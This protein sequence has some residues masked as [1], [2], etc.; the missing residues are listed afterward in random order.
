MPGFTVYP[1]TKEVRTQLGLR[2]WTNGVVVDS[3]DP[4]LGTNP[5]ISTGD[6]IMV[7][8]SKSIKSLR[9]FYDAVQYGKNT[10]TVLRDG[11]TFKVS[12]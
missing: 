11:Q 4:T 6:I 7:V 3:V 1:L 10:Y 2:N 9:D 8:N 12:F 5:K